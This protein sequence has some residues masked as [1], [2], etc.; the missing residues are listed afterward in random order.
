MLPSETM[1]WQPEFTDKT[2][3]RKPGAVQLDKIITIHRV[4]QVVT[5]SL[6]LRDYDGQVAEA[7]PMIPK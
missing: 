3:S 2:L 7:M 4:K 1:I 5:A 6:K